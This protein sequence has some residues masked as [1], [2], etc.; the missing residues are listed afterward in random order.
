MPF[1][2]RTGCRPKSSKEE[3]RTP[4]TPSPETPTRDFLKGLDP[5]AARLGH[6]GDQLFPLE[7]VENGQSGT[8]RPEECLQTW[9]HGCRA[10]KSSA[11]ALAD[12]HGTDWESA[13]Q[14]LGHAHGIG[15]NARVLVREEPSSRLGFRFA[16]RPKGGD[17]RCACRTIA[18]V[19]SGIPGSP[20]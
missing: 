4:E 6:M 15:A 17:M 13:A 11:G 16:P 10:E 18:A 20:G 3:A 5:R 2:T 7:D 12:P 19:R 9:S 8:N 14:S 1:P